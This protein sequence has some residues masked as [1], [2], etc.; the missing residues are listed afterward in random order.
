MADRMDA[1]FGLFGASLRLIG[2]PAVHAAMAPHLAGLSAPGPGDEPVFTLTAEPQHDFPAPADSL[3]L[4]DGPLPEGLPARLYQ[5]ADGLLLLVPG[6]LSLHIAASGTGGR[7]GIA[8]GHEAVLSG[9]PGILALDAAAG[10]S[11]QALVHAAA[12]SLPGEDAAVLLCAPSGAGKTS[13]ALALALA[14][15]GLLTDDSAMLSPGPGQPRVWGL[16]RAVKLH[17]ATLELLPA[18]ATVADDRWNA[19]EEQA[20]PPG[21]LATL[22]PLPSPR[23]VPLVAI[24]SVG[25]RRGRPGHVV[26]RLPRADLLL[27]LAADNL[28]RGPAGLP[29]AERRRWHA[30]SAAVAAVPAFELRAGTDLSAL[31]GALLSALGRDG[32][33]SAV[34]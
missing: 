25:P 6:R 16:P 34:G 29:A 11:G 33:R 23:P 8:P 14:G 21:R 3:L 13:A 19:E 2:S 18:L 17:R 24:L 26:E 15:F 28:G 5:A 20:V 12:L 4:A 30:L 9:S 7:I 1:W 31:A 10:L 27:R 22:V 32:R